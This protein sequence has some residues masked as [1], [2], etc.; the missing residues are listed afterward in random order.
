MRLLYVAGVRGG[1]PGRG[2][3]TSQRGSTP[4]HQPSSWI[5]GNSAIISLAETRFSDRHLELAGKWRQTESKEKEIDS[6]I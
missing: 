4:L 3:G 1:E 2:G 5:R 6:I